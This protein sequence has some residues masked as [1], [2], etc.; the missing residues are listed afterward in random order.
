[1]YKVLIVDDSIQDINGL[2]NHIDWKSLNCDV[3]GTALNGAEG[4]EKA[5]E[6]YPD[7]I[8]SDVSMPLIDGIE[9]TKNLNEIMPDI[10]YI[11]ISC[12]DDSEF[13]KAALD[14][15]VKAYIFKPIDLVQFNNTIKKVVNSLN[16]KRSISI[17]HNTLQTQID[18]NIHYLTEQFFKDIVSTGIINNSRAELLKIDISKNYYI[19][20]IQFDD[21]DSILMKNTY[22]YFLKLTS[23]VEEVFPSNNN[24]IIPYDWSKIL[25]LIN[26]DASIDEIMATLNKIQSE[27]HQQNS[28]T[29]SVF[30]TPTHHPLKDLQEIVK[31]FTSVIEQQYF[32]LKNQ[33]I[34]LDSELDLLSFKPNINFSDLSTSL[35]NCIISNDVNNIKTLIALYLDENRAYNM[36]YIKSLCFYFISAMNLIL[37]EQNENFSN[38]FDDELLLWQKLSKINSNVNIRLWLYNILKTTMEYLNKQTNSTKQSVLAAEIKTY[39]DKNYSSFTLSDEIADNFFITFDYANRIFKNHYHKTILSYS[40][41]KKIEKAKKLLSTTN[42]KITDISTELGYSSNPYFSLAFKKITGVSPTEYR[43]S[44][45]TNKEPKHD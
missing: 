42:M 27:F 19:S 8:I 9:M 32:P 6:L 31:S 23:A 15:D 4:I 3:V 28:Y 13:L 26:S 33:I 11:Y 45:F 5:K 17:L 37:I 12:F 20:L 1:M 18:T 24:I 14:N 40:I 38:I 21:S 39:I 35:R 2:L 10:Q 16:D 7:I 34:M 22:S 43:A 25:L 41:D 36:S 30:I 29:F 44:H